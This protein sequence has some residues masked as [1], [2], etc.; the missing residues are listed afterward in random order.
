MTGPRTDELEQTAYFGDLRDHWWNLDHLELCARR[1]GLGTVRSVLDVGSGVGHWGRLLGRVLPPD[2]TVVGIDRDPRWVEEATRRAAEAG[3]TG[4]YT[5]EEAS[6]EALPFD[7]E[8]FD[9]VTCQTLLI[10]VPDPREVIREMVRV[11]KPG[12]LV[13]ASE[14]N[15]HAVT[16]AETSLNASAPVADKTDHVGFYLTCERGKE[17]LGEG[18]L[19]VG[20]LVPG[21]F[22]Q[23]GLDAL[24]VY[25]SDKALPMLPPYD[26]DEQR[27]LAKAYAEEAEYGG[28]G[29]SRDETRRYYLAGGGSEAEFDGAWERRVVEYNAVLTSIE[30]GTFTA[31]GLPILYL[32]AGRR[33]A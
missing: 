20:E 13:L 25:V 15:N 33:P 19:S 8:S 18:N 23:E 5:Y 32:I 2:T 28:W 17:A 14:P 31:L 4:R 6:A 27:I 3:V 16:L 12:G 1:L 29:W 7:D 10:H 22:R 24:Q 26:T 30:D 11:T 21:Y 9:L